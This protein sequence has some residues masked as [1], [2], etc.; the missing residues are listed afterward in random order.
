MPQSCRLTHPAASIKEYELCW[1]R[2]LS[3]QNSIEERQFLLAVDEHHHTCGR[4][5][6]KISHVLRTT[7]GAWLI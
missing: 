5:R 3:G 2:V 4:S 1:T 6:K 7:R